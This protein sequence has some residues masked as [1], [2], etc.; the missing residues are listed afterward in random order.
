VQRTNEI[1][2]RIALGAQRL[3]VLWMVLRQAVLMGVIG[4]GIGV[5]GS[6]FA[7]KALESL[8][9]GITPR[10]PGTFGAVALLLLSVAFVAALVPAW[11]ATRVDP[12]SALRAE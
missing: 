3:D 5:I 8:V 2:I 7:T 6:C 4:V 12:S 9:F 1:G 10:D 11:R